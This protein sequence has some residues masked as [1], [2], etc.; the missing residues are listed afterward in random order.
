MPER[1]PPQVIHLSPPPIEARYVL[2]PIWW[3][4]AIFLAALG[5]MAIWCGLWC[6]DAS[7]SPLDRQRVPNVLFVIGGAVVILLP[8]II[9]QHFM[10]LRR[11]G[12]TRA[13]VGGTADAT[14]SQSLWPEWGLGWERP[15]NHTIRDALEHWDEFDSERATVVCFPGVSLPEPGD[16][17]SEPVV[18]SPSAGLSIQQ[19]IAIAVFLILFAL[20]QLGIFGGRSSPLIFFYF[21]AACVPLVFMTWRRL[22]SP[23]YY[24]AAP[25]VIQRLHFANIFG[26]RPVIREYRMEPGTLA[27]LSLRPR[28][29]RGW[30][31][32]PQGLWL[33]VLRQENESIFHLT[34]ADV[35]DET[36]ENILRLLV[37]TAPVPPL[38]PTELIG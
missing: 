23:I 26:G 27:I 34:R 37:S 15:P 1:K 30:S 36:R 29:G 17:R 6:V 7:F 33:E 11:I 3:A 8:V 4:V 14:L 24:R 10:A 35:D 9:G 16:Y 28:T 20:M 18:V 5:L 32:R 38:S 31:R 2:G 22:A 19:W 21:L 12:R 13:W 25:G